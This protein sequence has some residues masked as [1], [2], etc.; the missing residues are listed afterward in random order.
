MEYTWFVKTIVTE[1][2]IRK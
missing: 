1:T 2:C